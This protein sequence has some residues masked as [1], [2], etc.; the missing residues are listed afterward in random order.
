MIKIRKANTKHSHLH[1]QSFTSQIAVDGK[2]G[3][4]DGSK[5]KSRQHNNHINMGHLSSTN[6][7]NY[8]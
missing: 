2:G 3:L 4:A 1:T 5:E 7:T 8:W 6:R